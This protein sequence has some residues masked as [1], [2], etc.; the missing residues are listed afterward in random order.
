LIATNIL[1]QF[2][3]EV[4]I[5]EVTIDW[6]NKVKKEFPTNEGQFKISESVGKM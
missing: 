2:C 3:Q 1:V 5:K 6:V 4:G